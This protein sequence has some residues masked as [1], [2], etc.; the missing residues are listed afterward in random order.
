[1]QVL[2]LLALIHGNGIVHRDVRPS[3]LVMVPVTPASSETAGFHSQQTVMLIDWGFALDYG[4][5]G[6]EPFEAVYQ[7]AGQYVSDEV[8]EHLQHRGTIGYSSTFKF[9]FRDDMHSWVRTFFALTCPELRQRLHRM[10]QSDG[11][12]DQ[13]SVRKLWKNAFARNP[14]WKNLL[15]AATAKSLKPAS[16]S[17]LVPLIPIACTVDLDAE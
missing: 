15:T 5:P 10:R 3:N 11:A 16:Y 1:M 6:S 2:E 4:G 12:V 7:G 9:Q 8:S 14:L 17:T 13:P